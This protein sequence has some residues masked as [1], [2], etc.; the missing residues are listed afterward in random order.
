VTGSIIGP[1]MFWGIYAFLDSLLRELVVEPVRI[2]DFTLLQSTDVGV[3][4]YMIMGILLVVLMVYRPQGV[5]GN[6]K[7]MAFEGR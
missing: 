2:G 4:V 6:K 1:M 5:F 3:V 7:E